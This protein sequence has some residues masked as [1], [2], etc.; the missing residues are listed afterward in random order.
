M[1]EAQNQD[2]VEGASADDSPP[3]ARTDVRAVVNYPRQNMLHELN[4]KS[5]SEAAESP[6]L[7]P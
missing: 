2:S 1:R 6:G 4:E 7:A 3:R 5:V